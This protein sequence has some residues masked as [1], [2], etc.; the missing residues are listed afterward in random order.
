MAME[1]THDSVPPRATR[2][3]E[4]R[5]K[6]DAQQKSMIIVQQLWTLD[7]QALYAEIDGKLKKPGNGEVWSFGVE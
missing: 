5:Y 7:H 1:L 3:Q 2:P 6:T 4:L